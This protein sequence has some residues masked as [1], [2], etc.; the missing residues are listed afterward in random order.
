M[1]LDSIQ[2]SLAQLLRP[3]TE[4]GL[5]EQLWGIAQEPAEVQVS[6]LSAL[7]KELAPS[8]P[9]PKPLRGPALVPYFDAA[10][11]E[12][13]S[14]LEAVRALAGTRRH[15]PFAYVSWLW[16]VSEVLGGLRR[17]GLLDTW[18]VPVALQPQSQPQP[19]P[20][21]WLLRLPLDPASPPLRTGPRLSGLAFAPLLLMASR[22]TDQLGRRRR[23]LEAARR[24]LLET[25]AR[26]AQPPGLVQAH[27]VAIAEQIGQLN[28]WQAD[29]VDPEADVSHQVAAAIVRR[30]L[31]TTRRLL[32]ILDGLTRASP[33]AT[34]YGS[35]LL[36]ARNVLEEQLPTPPSAPT[37]A[38]L[39][40]DTFGA[41]AAAAVSRG[42]ARAVAESDALPQA[43]ADLVRAGYAVDGAFEL[44]RS[45]APVRTLEVQRRMAEVDYPTQTLVLAPARRVSDL[46]SSMIQDPR[47]L[48]RDFASRALLSRRYR[49]ERTRRRSVAQRYSEARYYVLDGSASMAG[50]RGRMRDA[51]LVAELSSLIRHLEQ[52]TATA[53]PIVYYRYFSKALEPPVRAA[54]IQE[55]CAA[56]EAVLV[57]KSRGET[58]IEGALLASF[59]ELGQEREKDDT[60][61]R[62]QLVLVTDGVANV[63]LERVWA[64]RERLGDL[65]VRVSVIALGS[66]NVALQRLAGAQRAR[67]EDVFYH[68][69]SDESLY[70]LARGVKLAPGSLAPAAPELTAEPRAAVRKARVVLAPPLPALAEA[71]QPPE[72]K[73]STEVWRELD[74]LVAELS[75]LQAPPDVDG[76][77]QAAHLGAAYE[78]VGMSLTDVGLE[79]ERARYEAKRRDERALHARFDRWFPERLPAPAPNRA[80]TPDELLDVV[81]VA[82]CSVHELVGYLN[83]SPL[84]RCVDA[85]ELLEGLLGEAGVTPWEYGQA[86][87]LARPGARAAI[88]GLRALSLS[89]RA[90]QPSA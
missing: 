42:S 86:L 10:C 69:F 23:L 26:V 7:L 59:A 20:T 56:I 65:P 1:R 79:A 90:E 17:D 30:D 60:L 54:S 41:T 21:S 28:Q 14:N 15:P 36:R 62:A 84:Q 19:T 22:E 85:I 46:P 52:G 16:R 88:R 33:R 77:E 50:R 9:R 78:V 8:G 53:R 47:L 76:I 82:L 51:I 27:A 64:A 55:A 68:Y 32:N 34:P 89:G 80:P 35:R 70:R 73:L 87:P 39:T 2:A 45:V 13:E 4:R 63:D 24:L 5:F 72:P 44:G 40:R 48:L 57:R 29:G 67:G 83:G 58:D 37:L 66:E 6:A 43:E 25:A 75:L 31:P 71:R 38:E 81:E 74:S 3:P 12:L 11:R 49:A 61:K 18:S